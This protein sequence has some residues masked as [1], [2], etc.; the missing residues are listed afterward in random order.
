MSTVGALAIFFC[1]PQHA[2]SDTIASYEQARCSTMDH[3]T[4]PHY[5]TAYLKAWA[6]CKQ[7]SISAATSLGVS[8]YPGHVRWFCKACLITSRKDI[9]FREEIEDINIG[10]WF[11]FHFILCT[12]FSPHISLTTTY[13]FGCWAL[14]FNF[15]SSLYR[16][17]TS[18][19]IPLDCSI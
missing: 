8:S 17:K 3:T 13:F 5:I 6:S 12:I 11:L 9:V 15:S 16:D 19:R 7:W 4:N 18:P 2:T 1:W 10:M 14:C